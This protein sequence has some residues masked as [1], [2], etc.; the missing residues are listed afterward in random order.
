MDTFECLLMILWAELVAS[1]AQLLSVASLDALMQH[2]TLSEQSTTT[3]MARG[4]SCLHLAS[5]VHSLNLYSRSYK[6]LNINIIFTRDF[7][8][9]IIQPW[10]GGRKE[11]GAYNSRGTHLEVAPR[12][13]AK[14]A[15]V[16]DW[17]AWEQAVKLHLTGRQHVV[18]LAVVVLDEVR[19]SWMSSIAGWLSF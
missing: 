1:C 18:V 8:P 17:W 14:P 9:S 11:N 7:P 5:A 10:I 12:N 16:L 4:L 13:T 3:R 19:S 6:Q 2:S 15:I